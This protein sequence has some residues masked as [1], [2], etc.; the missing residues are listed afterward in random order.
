M[1]KS[2]FKTV[3]QSRFKTVPQSR[4]KIAP[5]S[6][7]KIVPQSRHKITVLQLHLVV[8]QFVIVKVTNRTD[9]LEYNCKH[10][11]KNCKRYI[12]KNKKKFFLIYFVSFLKI[13]VVSI[14]D[15]T[16]IYSPVSVNFSWIPNVRLNEQKLSS[17]WQ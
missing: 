11:I 12:Y 15:R 16:Q 10:N 14:K 13:T 5:Q 2:R 4:F 6:R 9:Y 17:F 8:F 1:P 7:S 3:P